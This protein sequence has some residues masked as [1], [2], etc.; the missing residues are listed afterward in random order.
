V[1]GVSALSLGGVSCS[2]CWLRCPPSWVSW[3]RCLAVRGL[4]LRLASSGRWLRRCCWVRFR[5]RLGPL[6]L[7]LGR[8]ARLAFCRRRLLVLGG[9]VRGSRLASWPRRF[10]PVVS[11]APFAARC[12]GASRPRCVLL[13][14]RVCRCCLC[15]L[16]SGVPGSLAAPWPAPAGS[17]GSARLLSPARVRPRPLFLASELK[18]CWLWRSLRPFPRMK[19]PVLQTPHLLNCNYLTTHRY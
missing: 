15:R 4:P 2:G 12:S 7:R 8:V 13:A 9:R 5:L 6:R 18:G 16:R 11:C 17:A 10:L 19:G 14:G 1:R 3:L